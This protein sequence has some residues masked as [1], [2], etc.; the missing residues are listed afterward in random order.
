M[1]V[2]HV[3]SGRLFGGIEQMLLTIARARLITPEVEVAFAVAAPGRLDEGLR[4]SGVEVVSLG[5]VRLSRPGSVVHARSR[6]ARRLAA[7]RWAAVVCHAPWSFALFARTARRRGIPVVC[8]Q[9]DHA[10]GRTWVERWSR[11]VPADLMICNSA[12]TARSA[13][14]LQPHAPVVVIHPPVM[15]AECPDASRAQVR[16]ELRAD[17]DAVVILCASRLEP[18]KGHLNVIRAAAQLSPHTKWELWI[19]GG[20]IRPHE[21]EYRTA[22][23]DEATALGLGSRV[24]LLGERRDVPN[25]M[26]AADVFCQFNDGPEPFG[27][28]F[29]EALLAG[30][31]VVAAGIGGAPEIVSS[32]CGR[33]VPAGNLS[34]LVEALRELIAD[35]GLRARL[36]AA[37]PAHAAG[38]C[39]PAVILPQLA[40]TLTL[41]GTPAAA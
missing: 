25:L 23:E 5:D 31:P 17:A 41:L 38:T 24:K 3:A 26:K 30:I 39:A 13:A 32:A 2:L 7:G 20:A 37:G 18:W 36:G 4:A 12:W 15:L 19:A 14:V 29:A 27:V 9:H 10:F 16:R 21:R 33:L 8:W 35:S 28:V 22:L 34:A 40:R 1:R 11:R 6:L